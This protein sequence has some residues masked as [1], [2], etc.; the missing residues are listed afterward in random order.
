MSENQGDTRF[1]G[2]FRLDEPIGSGGFGETWRAYD[3]MLDVDVALKIYRDPDPTRRDRY[4]REARSLARL[5]GSPGIAGVRDLLEVDGQ[6]CLVMDYVDG[7]DLSDLIARD[8]KLPLDFLQK[9]LSPVASALS[10]LHRNGII[11][12]DV[13][14]DNIRVG[15]NGLGKLLDFGS[16]LSMNQSEGVTQT[17]KPGYAPPEQY[18]SPD[19]QGPWSDVYALAAT[20]YHCLC[21][22]APSDSLRRTFADDLR[23]PSD[24]GI[25]LPAGVEQALMS[26]LEL[27]YQKRTQSMEEF[28]QGFCATVTAAS[29][30]G[31]NDAPAQGSTSPTGMQD[32]T[33]ASA[34]A[35]AHPQPEREETTSTTRSAQQ[36][37]TQKDQQHDSPEKESR[38]HPKSGKLSKRLPLIILAILVAIALPLGVSLVRSRS[39]NGTSDTSNQFSSSPDKNITVRKEN[40]T[41]D[42]I[43]KIMRNPETKTV[44]F[45]N[46]AVSQEALERLAQSEDI[47]DVGFS[48]CT[49]FDTLEPLANMKNLQNLGVDHMDNVDL[50]TLLPSHADSLEELRLDNLRIASGV[51]AVTRYG[52]LKS[53]KLSPVEGVSDVSWLADMSA[54][55]T[56]ILSGIDLSGGKVDVL[57]KLT[58]LG[59]VYLD[60]SNV[61]TLE[62]AK[63]CPDLHTLHASKNQITDISPLAD[64]AKLSDLRLAQ[65]QISD[66]TPLA[67]CPELF[68]VVLNNN[69]IS[70]AKGLENHV[71]ESGFL[72]LDTVAL[73]NN[74]LKTAEGL[75]GNP[76]LTWLYLGNNQLTDIS[77]IAACDQME[78]LDLS[79]NKLENLDDLQAMIR[80]QQL[81]ASHNKIVQIDKLSSCNHLQ[82]L[83]LQ[84]N[85]ISDISALSNGFTDL[86]AL[87]IAFNKIDSLSALK[88]ASALKE[89]ACN[90]NQ[91]TS[92]DG[93]QDKANLED[94]L[95]DSNQIA[96]ISALSSSMAKLENID[97]GHNKISDIA[98]LS[99]MHGGS[100]QITVLLDNNQLTSA[101][102]LPTQ[103]MFRGLALH[104]NPLKDF[105]ALGAEGLTFY[106][107]YLPYVEGADYS[108]LDK[109]TLSTTHLVDVPFDQQN[110]VLEQM[111]AKT[112]SYKN[113][114]VTKEQADADMAKLR[115]KLNSRISGITS[116][117]DTQEEEEAE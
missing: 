31:P 51:E 49:G 1:I 79:K 16:A 75:E 17:V 95:A 55:E 12:R 11:H 93:L 111:N 38:P 39:D 52:S 108:V 7:T 48:T 89:L 8:G 4:L 101:N 94:M 53:L 103:S 80:L 36:P 77:S 6:I 63:S 81:D 67:S 113:M 73:A 83:A 74:Q 45:S 102:G 14:P 33:P 104:G 109:S 98:T 107:L 72:G 68:S 88:S 116:T 18:G 66:L 2:R 29:D 61:D 91:I 19:T 26:A 30:G 13:S 92:L 41:P 54:L 64:H 9:A 84:D 57:S 40:V 96:D 3:E 21:G 86:K 20:A 10:E 105:A 32:E 35:D 56:V 47:T 115:E 82:L 114:F 58:K 99:D 43:D 15:H 110:H 97:L 90:N 46:C 27:D 25:T 37:P 23:K 87:N 5:S 112:T 34:Q 78:R 65:N 42:S 22:I 50:A 106:A 70:S 24:L 85:A 100:G 62:W 117:A 44:T 71:D 59:V 69:K 28:G 76:K 60:Q